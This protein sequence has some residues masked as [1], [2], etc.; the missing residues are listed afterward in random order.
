[1]N[2]KIKE[3]HQAL[4]AVEDAYAE[5]KVEFGAGMTHDTKRWYEKR[6]AE[7]KYNLA[8]GKLR[9]L[10]EGMERLGRKAQSDIEES[11]AE[12]WAQAEAYAHGTLAVVQLAI[13][14]VFGEESEAGPPIT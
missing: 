14:Q 8:I 10:R 4:N 2:P 11:H 5:A 12:G 13:A 9:L 7:A 1:M 3:L 6:I